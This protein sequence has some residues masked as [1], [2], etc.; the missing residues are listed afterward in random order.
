MPR[1]I[2]VYTNGIKALLTAQTQTAQ[3]QKA[4]AQTFRESEG[5]WKII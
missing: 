1:P 4:H 3:E 2:A 5:I